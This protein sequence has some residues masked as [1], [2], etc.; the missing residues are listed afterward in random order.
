MTVRQK[1]LIAEGNAE[2][3]QALCNALSKDFLVEV[4]ADGF[5]AKLLLQSLRPDVLLLDL[6]LTKIDAFSVLREIV[7]SEDR[8]LVVVTTRF[9]SEYI[10]DMLQKLPVDY[11]VNKPCKVQCVADRVR[12]LALLR[13]PAPEP[14][15]SCADPVRNALIQLAFSTKVD[16]F[17]YLTEAIPLYLQDPDQ[18]IT[19]ELYTAV[20]S[21][22]HKSGE[23][24]ERSIRSAIHSAWERRDERLWRGYF[25]CDPG[26]VVPRPSNGEFI[27]RMAIL[28]AGDIRTEQSA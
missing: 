24:V 27:S 23:Q 25:P 26:G 28:L 9:A 10:L 5:R 20:G 1:L 14:A 6:M 4:C 21:R 8:P 2:L 7:P 18:N 3:R 11:L 22:F 13:Q 16:G 12:E 17:S 19:K 15:L